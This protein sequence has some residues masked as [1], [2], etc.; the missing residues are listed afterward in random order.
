ME[1]IRNLTNFIR[2]LEII[3]KYMDPNIYPFEIDEYT[4][5][6]RVDPFRLKQMTDEDLAELKELHFTVEN[7]DIFT[8]EYTW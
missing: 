3:R 1:R 2:G 4:L 8:N 7:D 5:H 6:F